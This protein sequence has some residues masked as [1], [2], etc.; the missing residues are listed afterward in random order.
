MEYAKHRTCEECGESFEPG[1]FSGGSVC[2][3]CNAIFFRHTGK[4]L[5]IVAVLTPILLTGFFLFNETKHIGFWEA[6]KWPEIARFWEEV[7]SWQIVGMWAVIIFFD[8]MRPGHGYFWV[9]HGGD[10]EIGDGDNGDG[11]NGDGGNGDY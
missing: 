5:L 11:G 8:Y 7:N 3:T 1:G 2:P 4:R 10:G 6:F 9:G